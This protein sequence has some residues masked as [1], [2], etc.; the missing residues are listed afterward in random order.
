MSPIVNW[1]DA[2][3]PVY[4]PVVPGTYP[5]RLEKS[6]LR[7]GPKGD[8]YSLEFIGNGGSEDPFDNKHVWLNSSL[9]PAALYRFKD[10]MMKL[11]AA[12]AD[13]VPGSGV[14]TDE[15]VASVLGADCQLV[16]GIEE[17]E[18]NE[19]DEHGTKIR[20]R[21]NGVKQ[22]LRSLSF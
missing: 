13:F 1:A 22:V 21:R 2:V 20:K 19:V 16:L 6:E 12:A 3:A 17:Y 8:Y 9:S 5:A 11:G 4:D 18:S 10:T 15:I 7:P 14:D